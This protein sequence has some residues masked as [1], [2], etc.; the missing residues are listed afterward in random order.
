MSQPIS[1]L[2]RLYDAH[3]DALVSDAAH[4]I[5]SQARDVAASLDGMSK[6][7]ERMQRLRHLT[8]SPDFD[9]RLAAAIYRSWKAA[10]QAR[11]Q[12]Q[13]KARHE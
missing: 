7:A 6:A 8:R 3:P 4:A 2:E 11:K 13:K 12:A 9:D 1:M 5:V 10:E